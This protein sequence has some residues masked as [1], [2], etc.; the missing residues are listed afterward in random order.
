MCA[1]DEIIRFQ[2]SM[3]SS[4]DFAIAEMQQR[5]QIIESNSSPVLQFRAFSHPILI[6]TRLNL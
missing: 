2:F 1:P 5:H 4:Q 6:P 3:C